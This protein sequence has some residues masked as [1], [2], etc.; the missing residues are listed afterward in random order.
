MPL[1]NYIN[2]TN[3]ITLLEGTG[4]AL[5]LMTRRWVD[6]LADSD[7]PEN[8]YVLTREHLKHIEHFSQETE[9]DPR[10]L[11]LVIART[12]GILCMSEEWLDLTEKSTS[13]LPEMIL[14]QFRD[15]NATL[16]NMLYIPEK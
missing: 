2:D 5:E 3:N 12:K 11:A 4:T 13:N 1:N 14:S 7:M 15:S 6:G 8:I 10:T 9:N 16:R